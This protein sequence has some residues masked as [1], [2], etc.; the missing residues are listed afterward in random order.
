MTLPS[1]RARVAGPRCGFASTWSTGEMRRIAP[2]GP[3]TTGRLVGS[4]TGRTSS[5]RQDAGRRP[6]QRL[7]RA[8]L[9]DCVAP[10]EQ[11]WRLAADRRGEVVGLKRVR[12]GGRDLD[13]LR[14]VVAAQIDPGG[15]AMP[16]IGE[17]QGCLLAD[18]LQ[19]VARGEPEPHVEM[20]QQAVR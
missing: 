6:V 20:R 8:R 3:T 19:I 15:E 4:R 14:S 2:P 1:S 12:I 9:V 11:W 16:G 10:A 13:P 5:S 18:D 17:I 7:D